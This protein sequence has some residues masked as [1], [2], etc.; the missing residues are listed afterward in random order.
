MDTLPT[1]PVSFIP[2]YVGCYKCGRHGYYLLANG[3]RTPH[4]STRYMGYLYLGLLHHFGVVSRHH[5]LI[6]LREME[7]GLR[8]GKMTEREVKCFCDI[9][10]PIIGTVDW[11]AI[12]GVLDPNNLRPNFIPVRG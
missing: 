7:M 4:F 5:Q 8:E 11:S 12:R 10:Y 3:M 1:G 6:M 9:Q 2:M